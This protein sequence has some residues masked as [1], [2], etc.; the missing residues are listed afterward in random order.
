MREI[1]FLDAVGRVDE[2]FVDE[3]LTYVPPRKMNVWLRRASAL[4]ACF[5]AIVATV[6][7]VNHINQ[8]KIIDENGFYIENGVLLRYT[9]AETDITLPETVESV[10]DFAFLEN[11]NAKEIQVVRLGASVKTVEANA[12]AGLENLVDLIIVEN[13]LS[14]VYEDGLIMTSDGSILLRYEREGET[15]FKIPDTVKII[16][17][18]AVQS[19]KLEEIDF[20]ESLEYIGFYA[21]AGDSELKAIYLPDTVKHI[22]DGAFAGCGSAVDGHVPEGVEIGQRAFDGVPFYLSMLAGR[23]C[24]AE[25]IERG[26]VTPSQAI[27]RSNRDALT[28]Q[29]EYILAAMRGDEGYLPSDLGRFAYGAVLEMPEVPQDMDI[30]A[31]FSV[32]DLTFADQGWGRTAIDDLQIFLDAGDYTIAFE[33][34]G[35]ALYYE[36]YWDDAVFRIS[37]VYFIQNIEDVDPDHTF[38]GFGWTAVFERGDGVYN[39][40]TFIHEDGTI[41][42]AFMPLISVTPY[43]LTFSPDGTRVAVE[44]YDGSQT[45]LY[46]QS[47]NGDPLMEPNYDYNEYM[48]RYWGRYK[49]GTLKWIGNDTIEGVNE[50]GRFRWNIRNSFEIAQLE[51]DED[52]MLDGY[53]HVTVPPSLSAD[54]GGLPFPE[55]SAKIKFTLVGGSPAIYVPGGKD[56]TFYVVYKG[57]PYTYYESVLSLPNGYE[58]GE[59]IYASGGGGSGEYFMFVSAELQGEKVLLAYYFYS[60]G[61]PQPD[62]VV[63][64]SGEWKTYIEEQAYG[65]PD[66]SDP[67]VL[68]GLLQMTVSETEKLYGK[69]TLEYSEHGPSQPVYSVA[70]LSGVNLVFHGHDMNEPLKA[71]MKPAEIILTEGYGRK[72]HGLAV[73][74]Y[75]ESTDVSWGSAEYSIIDGTVTLTADFETYRVSCSVAI[76]WENIPE[77]TAPQS[78][79][80]AWEA[81]YLGDP[82]GEV[83]QIRIELVK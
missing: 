29:I 37:R 13:N 72:V 2:K 1:D 4:A 9:G 25:E 7:I 61:A 23:M 3:C 38:K 54:V 35:Y 50:F 77:D 11:K 63:I 33:A 28:E 21:F 81:K 80:D 15:Y 71:D 20:G 57:I 65:L 19:T 17:A 46:I 64:M 75:V 8:P 60:G 10:A 52:W 34:Y 41:I 36:L 66:G 44:Y 26:L 68:A 62:E 31:E 74:D 40:I 48:G 53:V 12:F 59:I 51:D 67:V 42:R 30:P 82:R 5:A 47:L 55:D 18:H 45:F 83:R 79:W 56:L 16:A 14:F 73:R 49:V 43:I 27:L 69:L 32:S 78:E 58:N 22:G 76:M 70:N 6:L 39:G 24:P